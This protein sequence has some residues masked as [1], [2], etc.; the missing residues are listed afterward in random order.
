MQKRLEVISRNKIQTRQVMFRLV[1]KVQIF[2]HLELR[3]QGLQMG[4]YRIIQTCAKWRPLSDLT[5]GGQ[6]KALKLYYPS[7]ARALQYR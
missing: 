5:N 7:Y 4:L 3:V 1:A 6:G 2:E